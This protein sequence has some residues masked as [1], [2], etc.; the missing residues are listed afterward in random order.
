MVHPNCFFA[1]SYLLGHSSTVVAAVVGT[2]GQNDPGE[3]EII[4]TNDNN[5]ML[6]QKIK[7]SL[8][9]ETR[10]LPKYF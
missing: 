8:R 6:S 7:I 4:R 3:H 1:D 10:R 5:S 9:S 2:S